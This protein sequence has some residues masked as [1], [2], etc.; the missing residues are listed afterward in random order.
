[1]NR[2]ITVFGGP[3]MRPN[4][5]I[6]DMVSVYVQSLEWPDSLVDGRIYNVGFDNFKV[7]EIAEM[8]RG[9]VGTDVAIATKP[10]DDIRSYHVSSAKIARELG[11]RA[12]RT[13]QDAVRD[14]VGA[15]KKGRIPDP[16]TDIRYYNIRTMQA[17]KLK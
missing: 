12:T 15:F 4:I 17:L 8:V 11:F 10:S 2:K 13:V 14:L 6:D 9:V 1:V 5:H 3:Q 16:L 7:A